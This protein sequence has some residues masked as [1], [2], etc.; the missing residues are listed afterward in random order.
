MNNNLKVIKSLKSATQ[1]PGVKELLRKRIIQAKREAES[2]RR[3][4]SRK[5]GKVADHCN[6]LAKE[7][8]MVV[9]C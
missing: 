5:A 9:N 1:T 8:E 7:I 2:L 3:F 4:A 6:K